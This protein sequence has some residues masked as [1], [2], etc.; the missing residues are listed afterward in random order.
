MKKTLLFIFMLATTFAN[1]QFEDDAESYPLGP[2]FQGWWTNWSN[3]SSASAEN[4]IVSTDVAVSGTKSFLIKEGP[5]GPQD[6]VL[7]LGNKTS[8][9]WSISFKMYIPS[10]ASAYYNVQEIIPIG[11]GAWGIN[12]IFNKEG[13]DP[14]N[15]VVDDDSSPAIEQA[16]FTYPEDTWFDVVHVFDVDADTVILTING[17]E[18]Y[19]GSAFL[20]GQLGGLDFFSFEASNRYYMD[21]FIYTSAVASVQ[22][23]EALGFS[24]Y[25]NPVK[26]NLFLNANENI[27]NVSIYN[28]I[29]QE[30]KSLQPNSLEA[31]IDMS[32]LNSG[33][34]FVKVNIGSTVGTIKVMK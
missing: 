3:D 33:A 12:I 28:V 5:D 4:V 9:V 16:T 27:I 14:S 17:V 20:S 23:L 6:A 31:T 18:V 8:G 30:V 2:L 29:G 15:G 24:A 11:G 1:A 13:N 26:D 34:Y 32:D 10:G 19:N 7:D 22:D 25:P 21:D